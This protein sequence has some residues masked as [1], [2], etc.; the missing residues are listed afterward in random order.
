[1]ST[2]G[3]AWPSSSPILK[4]ENIT[5]PYSVNNI[6]TQ[7]F[8]DHGKKIEEHC[9]AQPGGLENTSKVHLEYAGTSLVQVLSRVGL[10]TALDYTAMTRLSHPL[11]NFLSP[12]PAYPVKEW[13]CH[14]IRSR[15]RFGS[16]QVLGGWSWQACNRDGY[17]QRVGS[18]KNINISSF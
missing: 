7:D 9:K 15:R 5:S 12:M 13:K 11:S 17:C 2:I 1:M 4:F 3:E 16:S 18:N 10:N 8:R 6:I 14:E